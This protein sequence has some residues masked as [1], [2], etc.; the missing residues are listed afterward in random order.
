VL[1]AYQQAMCQ[2]KNSRA[3]K[4]LRAATT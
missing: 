2:M 3:L 4:Q 1:P